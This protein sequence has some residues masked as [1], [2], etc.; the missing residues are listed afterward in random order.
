[1]FKFTG[2]RDRVNWEGEDWRRTLISSLARVAG[3][4]AFINLYSSMGFWF[5][6]INLVVIGGKHLVPG[7]GDMASVPV[8]HLLT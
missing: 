8:A 1:L 7:L 2:N 3:V 5:I 4:L 6:G